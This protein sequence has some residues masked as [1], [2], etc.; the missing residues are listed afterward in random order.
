MTV[1]QAIKNFLSEKG[2]R[3]SPKTMKEY[4]D[5]LACFASFLD[6]YG[7]C[8]FEGGT[9]AS[10]A[11]L[12]CGDIG[13]FLNWF[14]IRKL[15]S[16]KTE[17]QTFGR[18][19][20]GFYRWLQKQGLIHEKCSRE[21]LNNLTRSAAKARRAADRLDKLG[22]EEFDERFAV[23]AEGYFEITSIG[24]ETLGLSHL[25]T[26]NQYPKVGVD[27]KAVERLENGGQISGRLGK[28]G[29]T[30]VLLEVWNVY[31]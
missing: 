20:R 10:A 9:S 5:T 29:S 26:G 2:S 22:R 23:V 25:E 28:R 12:S 16:S 14:A 30:L 7:A 19:L 8:G 21:E 31:P 17:L 27:P 4:E 15:S 6:G 11:E 1:S 3:L 24:K 18:V 13:Y